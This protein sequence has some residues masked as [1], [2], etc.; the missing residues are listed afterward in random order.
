MIR[1]K[2]QMHRSLTLNDN[3]FFY[4]PDIMTKLSPQ[5]GVTPPVIVETNNRNRARNKW[6]NSLPVHEQKEYDAYLQKLRKTCPDNHWRLKNHKKYY[7]FC[8]N[9]FIQRH[10][11]LDHFLKETCVQTN[12][13]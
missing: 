12:I 3:A 8:K 1:A 6:K 10:C 2:K 5:R 11:N 7:S 9:G 13:N 4:I